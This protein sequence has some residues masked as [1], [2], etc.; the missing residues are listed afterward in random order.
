MIKL[1]KIAMLFSGF[2]AFAQIPETDIF[3]ADIEIKNNLVK[4]EKVQKINHTKAYNNQPFF[5]PDN[6]NI[7]FSSETNGKDKIHICRY[8]IKGKKIKKLTATQTSEYSPGLAPDGSLSSVVVEEDSTQRIWLFDVNT[9]A[10]KACVHTGTDSVG[11]YAWLG[12]DSILYYKLTNPHSLRVLNLKTGEDNWLCDHPMR[13]FKKIDAAT[14]FYVIHEEKHNLIYFFDIRTQKATLYANDKPQNMDY[15]WQPDLGLVKSE[16]SRI[17]RYSVETK[18]WAEVADF[19]SFGIK[20]ITRFAF[21]ADKKRI[22]V[23]S[24]AV[25]K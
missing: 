15:V 20:E 17:Y 21:S 25:E 19:S 7:L 14:F 3:V 16:Q 2:S 4:V 12:K 11:Y 10:K 6:K 5:T 1:C 13:S 23:V 22:A 8:D 18:V 24:N 9:G